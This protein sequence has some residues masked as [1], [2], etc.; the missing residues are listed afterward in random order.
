MLAIAS[1]WQTFQVTAVTRYAPLFDLM[2]ELHAAMQK[3]CLSR[4]D[5][6]SMPPTPM[7]HLK[8]AH[9]DFQNGDQESRTVLVKPTVRPAY[10]FYWPELAAFASAILFCISAF[11]ASRLKVAPRCIGGKSRNVWS[12]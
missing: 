10:G 12:S 11:T 5:G 3:F 4:A 9:P 8:S 1:A 2:N 7:G 6:S